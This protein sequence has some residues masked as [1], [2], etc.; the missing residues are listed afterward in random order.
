MSLE[1]VSAAFRNLF[2]SGWY[3]EELSLAW[4][5][6]E[7]LVAPIEFYENSTRRIHRLT[8]QDIIVRQHFQT[9]ATLITPEWCRFFKKIDARVGVSIDGPKRINDLKR[10][11]R[12]GTST[13]DRALEGM[14]L[15]RQERVDFDVIS[16]L[17]RESLDCPEELYS[18]YEAEEIRR[19]AFNIEEIEGEKKNSSL[20]SSDSA[21]AYERFLHVFWDLNAKRRSL[22]FIREIDDMRARIL[23]APGTTVS[24]L[25]AEPFA[26][27][28]VDCD[29]NFSTFCPEFLGAKSEKYSDFILG[30]V[31][32]TNFSDALQSRT[33]QAITQDI[34]R[35]VQQC[36]KECEFFPVC[37]GGAPV[38]KWFERGTLDCTETLHCRLNIKAVGNVT[39]DIVTSAA[40]PALAGA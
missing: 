5:A 33:L 29:G 9:N 12:S 6:G 35:G 31:H 38:N 23:S 15:L 37:G 24:N 11:S 18:F 1:T 8:H 3:G 25:L 20:T 36:E 10:N 34:Q 17:S 40:Q 16:V 13:F 28:S 21:D 26:I 7:P 22:D 2:D 14:R 30:D 32:N 27:I 4:H 39:M 19:L